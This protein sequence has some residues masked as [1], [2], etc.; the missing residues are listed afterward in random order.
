VDKL[1]DLAKAKG[2]SPVQM[3]LAWEL[4]QWEVGRSPTPLL[5]LQLILRCRA[6]ILFL[7]L[8]DL[9]VWKNA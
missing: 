3:I 2:V 5:L 9:K 7:D 4:A 8:R 1:G 6:Y